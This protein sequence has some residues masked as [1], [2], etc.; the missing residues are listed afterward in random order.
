MSIESSQDIGKKIT[1]ICQFVEMSE[2][3]GRIKIS[4]GISQEFYGP[5][6]GNIFE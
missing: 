5:S 4:P 3:S 6:P 1:D 2:S